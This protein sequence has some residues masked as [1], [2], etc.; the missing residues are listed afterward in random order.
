[1][2]R[3]ASIAAAALLCASCADPPTTQTNRDSPPT[4]QSPSEW[5]QSLPGIRAGI[6]RQDVHRVL[7]ESDQCSTR[8]VWQQ[9]GGGGRRHERLW[10]V[11]DGTW[12]LA[13]TYSSEWV[14]ESFEFRQHPSLEDSASGRVDPE[15]LPG[16]GILHRSPSLTGVRYDPVK[17]IQAVNRMHPL[18]KDRILAVA[19][20]YHDLASDRSLADKHAIDEQRIFLVL[21]LLFVR[22]DGDPMMLRM[23]VGAP[24]LWPAGS[25]RESWPLFPLA[26]VDDIP[27]YL[28]HG[29]MLAG[30]PQSPMV[31]VEYCRE[32]CRLRDQP[33]APRG[34]PVSVVEKLLRSDKWKRLMENREGGLTAH[35]VT[36]FEDFVRGQAYV[37]LRPA[38]DFVSWGCQEAPKWDENARAVGALAFRWSEAEQG[39]VADRASEATGT[40]P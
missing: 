15:L 20:A 14:L 9:K 18:G 12:R 19:T 37:A 23:G 30:S 8:L 4:P 33:L 29:Y 39:F 34:C 22:T 6:A 1:M 40:S 2:T 25:E 38:Y 26:L 31:H 5:Q 7:R 13:L 36:W 11:E 17:L 24:D 16:L 21:R 3:R 10:L 28:T 32:H 27:F 35:G